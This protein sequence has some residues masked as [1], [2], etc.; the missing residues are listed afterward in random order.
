MYATKTIYNIHLLRQMSFDCLYTHFD[1]EWVTN[2]FGGMC[3][4]SSNHHTDFLKS[5]PD[6]SNFDKAGR[7]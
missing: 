3:R 1:G 2:P 7:V 5:E 4:R 6:W